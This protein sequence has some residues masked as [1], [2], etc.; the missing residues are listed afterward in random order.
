MSLQFS[1]V[2]AYQ[3]EISFNVT[4]MDTYKLVVTLLNGTEE[5]LVDTSE[6]ILAVNKSTF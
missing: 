4:S 2:A 3:E 5:K 6:K 1:R